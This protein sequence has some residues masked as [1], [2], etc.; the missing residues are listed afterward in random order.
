[1]ESNNKIATCRRYLNK[2]KALIIK[3]H[4]WNVYDDYKTGILLVH[5]NPCYYYFTR[6][7]ALSWTDILVIVSFWL[8]C[9]NAKWFS[10]PRVGEDAIH[11]EKYRKIYFLWLYSCR[12][13]N[14]RYIVM[15]WA[16]CPTEYLWNKSRTAATHYLQTNIGNYLIWF[17]CNSME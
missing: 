3:W 11:I 7:Q 8:R 9:L 13:H 1:M 4:V 12:H 10:F 5:S 6:W 2:I 14:K 15:L 17:Q 16:Y